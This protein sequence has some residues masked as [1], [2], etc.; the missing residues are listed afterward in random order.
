MTSYVEDNSKMNAVIMGR[1]TWEGNSN[2]S[3]T[4]NRSKTNTIMKEYL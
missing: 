4:S 2:I 3:S 1:R